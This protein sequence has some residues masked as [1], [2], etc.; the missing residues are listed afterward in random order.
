MVRKLTGW[1][2]DVIVEI[3]FHQDSGHFVTFFGFGNGLEE[4]FNILL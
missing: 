2:Y 3:S 4:N 1:S